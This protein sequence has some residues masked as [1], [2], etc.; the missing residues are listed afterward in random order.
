ML[1]GVEEV[2]EKMGVSRSVAYR[3]IKEWNKT[4]EKCGCEV[5]PGKIE[6]T[7][8]L[9]KL[10]GDKTR[11]CHRINFVECYTD[12]DGKSI[13]GTERTLTILYNSEV[14]TEN[15]V[16]KLIKQQQFQWDNRVIATTPEAAD[17]F[18]G[19]IVPGKEGQNEK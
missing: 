19:G 10:N 3:H 5:K 8:F 7:F 18:C 15:E 13:E 2:M 16:R 1:I 12:S 4:L 9:Y 11:N 17:A 14:I 6:Q